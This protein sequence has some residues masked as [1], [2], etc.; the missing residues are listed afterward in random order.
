MDSHPWLFRV[1]G[2]VA[3]PDIGHALHLSGAG[4]QPQSYH[5]SEYVAT[6]DHL[7]PRCTSQWTA[8]PGHRP[9]RVSEWVANPGSLVH[10]I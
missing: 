6:S 1:P 9:C 2:C 10:Q 7:Q 4:G 5:A 3:L 8:N